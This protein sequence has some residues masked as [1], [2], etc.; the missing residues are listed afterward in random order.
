MQVQVEV[1][2]Y[3]GYKA[4]ERPVRFRLD[5]HEYQ[6]GELLDQCYGAARHLLQGTRRRRRPLHTRLAIADAKVREAEMQFRHRLGHL[7]PVFVRVAP[8]VNE[9]GRIIGQAQCSVICRQNLR[10]C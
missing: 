10:T 9:A 6:V 5:G 7:L 8:A 1:D 3:S 4:D 2:R